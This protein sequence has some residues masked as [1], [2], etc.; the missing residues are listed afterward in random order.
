MDD[1]ELTQHAESIGTVLAFGEFW[2]VDADGLHHE[3]M[4]LLKAEAMPVGEKAV[5]TFSVEFPKR[6]HNSG[7]FSLRLT[8]GEAAD[9]AEFFRKACDLAQ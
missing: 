9:L 5:C 1:Q 7:G 6:E 8:R 2:Q 4:L 3:D